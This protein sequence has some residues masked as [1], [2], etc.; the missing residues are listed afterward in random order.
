MADFNALIPIGVP[1]Y[2]VT[3]EVPDNLLMGARQLCYSLLA[4][5]TA[6]SDLISDGATVAAGGND[7]D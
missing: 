6:L 2:T 3:I 7:A 4:R 5:E 1:V